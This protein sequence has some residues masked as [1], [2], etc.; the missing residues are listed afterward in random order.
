MSSDSNNFASQETIN[1]LKNTLTQL[2]S[3][4]EK[5]E[6]DSLTNLPDS[7]TLN[8]LV[9]TTEELTQ[10]LGLQDSNQK[11]ISQQ[12]EKKDPNKSE[13]K[14]RKFEKDSLSP[15][16]SNKTKKIRKK[17]RKKGNFIN[18]AIVVGLSLL[19]LGY[20]VFFYHPLVSSEQSIN[21]EERTETTKKIELE[22][23]TPLSVQEESD[24]SK[25]I[26]EPLNQEE[27]ETILTEETRELE[28]NDLINLPSTTESNNREREETKTSEI[29]PELTPSQEKEENP[30]I[31]NNTSYK[32]N[33]NSELNLVDI[34]K[35]TLKKVTD[36]Y[37][38][39]LVVEVKVNLAKNF[40]VISLTNNWYNLPENQQK[41]LAE[42]IFK[43]VKKLDFT[44]LKI[45]DNQGNLVAR[46]ARVGDKMIIFKSE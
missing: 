10:S 15:I 41:K 42:T 31:D 1:I 25:E 22:E 7:S 9:I 36:K 44:Q 4:V 17:S 21:T 35:N 46:S 39:N 33:L 40:L 24:L 27:K 3:V 5:I 11:E 45:T 2:Q 37:E 16:R 6:R 18:L 20:F 23:T 28:Q 43:K 30:D 32:I 19:I 38:E 13:E 26:I 12:V 8:Q 29:E 14:S 34:I